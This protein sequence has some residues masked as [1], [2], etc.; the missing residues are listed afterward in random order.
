MMFVSRS[1][2]VLVMEQGRD[3]PPS[4][5]AM[6]ARR[7]RCCWAR[8]RDAPWSH[9]VFSDTPEYF[10]L[11]LLFA[12]VVLPLFDDPALLLVLL[13][14]FFFRVWLWCRS[15]SP[16]EVSEQHDDESHSPS[17]RQSR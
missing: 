5:N 11:L 3:G 1:A 17:E 14:A 9:L 12:I 7:G 10:A 16:E 2:T 15:A 8:L 4:P 13:G 6:P